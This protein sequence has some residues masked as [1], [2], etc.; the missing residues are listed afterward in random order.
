MWPVLIMQEKK[1]A[2]VTFPWT[3][4]NW[5]GSEAVL[6]KWNRGEENVMERKKNLAYILIML[7][8][9]APKLGALPNSFFVCPGPID[10]M[11]KAVIS[12]SKVF[13]N[14]QLCTQTQVT[15]TVKITKFQVFVIEAACFFNLFPNYPYADMLSNDRFIQCIA[16]YFEHVWRKVYADSA[17]AHKIITVNRRVLGATVNAPNWIASF[18]KIGKLT[19]NPDKKGIEDFR[20][21]AQVNFADPKP[22]GT[23]PF[24]NADV[25]QEEILFLIYPE[26]FVTQLIVP[27][28]EQNECIVVGGVSRTNNYTGYK[29]TFR[30]TG[31][32][33]TDD[34]SISI[35]FIDAS[36]GHEGLSVKTLEG[37]MNRDLNK[38]YLGFSA[39]DKTI[40]TGHWGCGAFGGN[41]QFMSVIQ[42]LAAAE[43]EKSIVYA[44][45]GELIDGFGRF[46][47]KLVSMSATVGEIY[48]GLLF[49]ICKELDD[50]YDTIIKVI[51]TLRKK[52]EK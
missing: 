22:G 21:A 10:L 13:P 17:W 18:K 52:N 35:I 41:Q 39:I 2:Y 31:D 48:S 36:K 30:F 19:I 24:A 3:S 15:S 33:T 38:A 20:D 42:L 37:K 32:F 12:G 47:D 50:Y 25:V 26:L 34:N 11:I 1:N 14:G 23:L 49:A 45:F 9:K 44:M 5:A 46:Y 16:N 28:M 29:R 6:K 4:P 7:G 43:A 51:H 27:N 40:A 8:V